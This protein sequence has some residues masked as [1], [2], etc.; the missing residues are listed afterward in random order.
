MDIAPFNG[1]GSVM[2]IHCLL[3]LPLFVE[4]LGLVHVF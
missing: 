3:L 1:G 4:S 2:S